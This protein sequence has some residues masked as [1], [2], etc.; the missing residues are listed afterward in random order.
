MRVIGVIDGLRFLQA[1]QP[2]KVN[3]VVSLRLFEPSLWLILLP[4]W[5]GLIALLGGCSLASMPDDRFLDAA[6]P[7]IVEEACFAITPLGLGHSQSPQSGSS[8]LRW[9][10]KTFFSHTVIE[11]RPHLV[12]KK[13]G[14]RPDCLVVDVSRACLQ[15][16]YLPK[17]VVIL[18]IIE[19]HIILWCSITHPISIDWLSSLLDTSG[20]PLWD[21]DYSVV[22]GY[23]QYYWR[24]A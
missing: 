17:Q 10:A 21:F 19:I 16:H 11:A 1:R 12:K 14:V 6:C 18:N 13:V 20:T 9:G 24:N 23:T 5:Q 15:M 2:L 22:L 3:R 4:L 8:P 7:S